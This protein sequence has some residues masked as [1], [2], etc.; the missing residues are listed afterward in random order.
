LDADND[1]EKDLLV[2]P[3]DHENKNGIW[4]YENSGTTASPV[5][6]LSSVNFLQKNMIDVGEDACP[7][8]FD[9]NN[10]NLLDLVFSKAVFNEGSNTYETGLMLYKNVGT[11]TNPAFEFVTDN[12]ANLSGTGLFLSPTYPAFGDLDADGDKDMMIGR[13]D[14]RLYY[15]QNIASVGAPA[16]FQSPVV[17]YM[18]I[19]IGKYATPQLYDLNKDGLLDIICGG[20]RGFVNYFQNTG[21]ANVPSFTSLPTNDTLGCINLQAVGTPDGF[22]VPF[23]YD[24]VGHTRLLVASE[25]GL[26]N[27]YDQIDGNID[28]CYNLAGTVFSPSE[29]SR[30]KFNITVSGAD[31]NG[32]TLIDIIIGQSA[33]G[34][35]IRYQ[36]DPTIGITEYESINPAFDIFPNPVNDIMKIRFYDLKNRNPVL[37][38]YNSLGELLLRRNVVGE[39]LE[40]NTSSLKGGIYF[41]QLT[42]GKYSIGKKFL[43][44]H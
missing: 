11:T 6:N 7:V 35:E 19:D 37:N 14:G 42:T 31:I 20:Q 43:V 41:L 15:Y 22:T 12:Y 24:S 1:G 38:I 4:L 39:N 8:F 32:D 3:Y 44:T 16:S 23:F 29:S 30:I 17:N 21:S 18:G 34:A 13:E 33:G 26:I 9:Y 10:D 5:F 2:M 36:H 40:I 27:Q 25:N 28:G